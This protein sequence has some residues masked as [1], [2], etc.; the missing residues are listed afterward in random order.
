MAEEIERKFLVAGDAWR[1]LAQPLLLRQG[2]LAHGPERTVRVRVAGDRA[3]RGDTTS[4]T[5]G[6]SD[7]SE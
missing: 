5:H 1:G 2:Y 6:K 3:A 7:D 4:S